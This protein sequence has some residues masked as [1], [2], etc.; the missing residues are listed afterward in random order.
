MLRWEK[1]DLPCDHLAVVLGIMGQLAGQADERGDEASRERARSFFL[2]HVRPW[3]Q[4]ALTEV[5]AHAE[6]RFYRGAAA[7][8]SAF[9][10]TERRSYEA[11]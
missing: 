8:A 7:M 3:A 1:I 10:E 5:A 4:R 6:R 9:L 11:V 2:R